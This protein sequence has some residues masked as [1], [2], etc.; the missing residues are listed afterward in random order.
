VVYVVHLLPEPEGGYSAIVP[1]L[2]GCGSQGDTVE[3]A[4]SNVREAM[5]GYIESLSARGLPVPPSDAPASP[6]EVLVAV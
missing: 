1:A 5:E 2:P 6:A 3:E 4:R